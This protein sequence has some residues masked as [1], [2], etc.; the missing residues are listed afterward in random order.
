MPRASS[1]D[2]LRMNPRKAVHTKREL[3]RLIKEV[4][5][6]ASKTGDKRLYDMVKW[7]VI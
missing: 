3:L 2:Y 1:N 5:D 4:K 6:Y 7:F